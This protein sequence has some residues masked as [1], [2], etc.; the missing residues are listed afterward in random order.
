MLT[1]WVL[2]TVA[3]ELGD[4]LGVTA[5]EAASRSGVRIALDDVTLSPTNIVILS[6][7]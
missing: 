6:P 3:K 4:N 2:E 5:L 1:Y 7:A